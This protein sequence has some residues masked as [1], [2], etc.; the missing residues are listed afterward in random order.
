MT[1]AIISGAGIVGLSLAL[2]LRQRG[3]TPVVVEREPRL[4]DGGYMLGLADPGLGAAERMGLADA[5]RAARYM[6]RR[7]A[8]MDPA[9]RKRSLSTALRS[10]RWWASGGSTSCAVTSSGRYTTA[11]AMLQR[12]ASGR[13]W[14]PWRRGGTM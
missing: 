11:S 5:L 14:N 8:Y 12:S 4:R 1:R 3:V 7:L 13:R 2:R 6:P 9:G 10:T